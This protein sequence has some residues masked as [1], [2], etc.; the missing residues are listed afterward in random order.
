MERAILKEILERLEKQKW[1]AR[2]TN[3]TIDQLATVAFGGPKELAEAKGF[4]DGIRQ[5]KP[6]ASSGLNSLLNRMP[7]EDKLK[8]RI[9]GLVKEIIENKVHAENYLTSLLEVAF[10]PAMRGARVTGLTEY[11]RTVHAEMAALLEALRHGT[12]AMDSTLYSTTF[13][14]HV[15]TRHEVAAGISRIVY[16]EPYPKSYAEEQH[17]DAISVEK[18]D[19]GQ[20]VN[21]VPFVGV[22]PRQYLPFFSIEF[23]ERE[24]KDD[25][26]N[27]IRATTNDSPMFREPPISYLNRETDIW[28]QTG[29]IIKANWLDE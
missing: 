3:Y 12:F 23:F 8:A 25:D 11:S 4:V 19:H 2:P 14:C 26:G 21:F 6:D 24:R 22:A 15:C 13:P 28:D 5:G 29:K 9:E 20:R 7:I 16:I 18:M 1:L 10:T 27:L 17:G